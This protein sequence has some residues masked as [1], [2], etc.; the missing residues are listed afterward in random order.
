MSRAA[1]AKLDRI[2]YSWKATVAQKMTHRTVAASATTSRLCAH[3]VSLQIFTA[4][5]SRR[6]ARRRWVEGV[7]AVARGGDHTSAFWT[8]G[9]AGSMLFDDDRFGPAVL[10]A[11]GDRPRGRH[12]VLS[13][14]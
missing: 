14:V 9:V 4:A 5:S 12:A 1:A 3:G 7:P 2:A 13:E 8:G 10:P 6:R 11:L